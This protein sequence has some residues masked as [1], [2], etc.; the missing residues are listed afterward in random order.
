MYLLLD[1]TN[2][3]SQLQKLETCIRGIKAW[4]AEN[5]L[6]LNDAKT[7][8]LHISSRL[9]KELNPIPSVCVGQ[10]DVVPSTQVRN[11]GAIMDQHMT[12]ASHV[13]RVCQSASLAIAKIGSIRK[14]I[15]RTTAERLVHAFV[16]SRLDANN[17]DFAFFF[18]WTNE[19]SASSQF[20]QL[21]SLAKTLQRSGT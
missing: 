2:R 1:S 21:F 12:S 6:L 5:K 18:V 17:R 13:N 10:E 11:L 3:D 8:V 9:L 20:V 15:D 7:E 14:Y 4:T 16:T 19:T